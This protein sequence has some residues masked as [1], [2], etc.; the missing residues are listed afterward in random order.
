MAVGHWPLGNMA[1]H[2][3][4][5]YL[6]NTFLVLSLLLFVEACCTKEQIQTNVY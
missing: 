3:E 6:D 4:K 1:L 5:W 2:S